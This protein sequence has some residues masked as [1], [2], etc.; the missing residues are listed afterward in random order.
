MKLNQIIYFMETNRLLHVFKP[1]R[2]ACEGQEVRKPLMC[3]SGCFRC[4]MTDRGTLHQC[5]MTVTW[6]DTTGILCYLVN[7]TFLRHIGIQKTCGID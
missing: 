5:S 4:D 6:Y 1:I 7:N 3:T 2:S